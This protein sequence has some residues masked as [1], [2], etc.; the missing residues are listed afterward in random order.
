MLRPDIGSMTEPEKSS[1]ACGLAA[2]ARFCRCSANLAGVERAEKLKRWF[3]ALGA[4]LTLALGLTFPIPSLAEE[5]PTD[6]ELLGA[7]LMFGFAGLDLAPND[8]VREMLAAGQL[9]SVILFDRDVSS[10]SDRNVESPEQIKTLTSSI[11][12]ISRLPVWIAIDQEGGQVRRLKPQKGFFD[13][14]S[15]QAMGH[16]SV[17][18]TFETADQLGRELATLGINLD[19]APV[20]DVDSNPFNPVIG[21]LGRAFNSDPA[22]VSLHALA[23]GRGLAKNGVVPVLK[24]F[25]GQGCATDDTHEGAA[26]VSACWSA[27]QDLRPYAEIIASGW[28]GMIMIGHI[29]HRGLDQ[30]LPA[31][32]SRNIV[33]GLLREGLGWQGVVISDDMQMRSITDRF[34]LKESMALAIEAGVD[35]LVFGNNL[36]FDPELPG[37]VMAAGRE[38]LATGRV[39]RE[40]LLESWH[41]IQTLHQAYEQTATA[42]S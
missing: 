28:P 30:Q 5:A 41:R 29:S 26:D 24:H 18:K 20:A 36:K 12:E 8:P 35:I 21:Q 6:D 13:L 7:M 34:D 31:S 9:G 40:R 2:E 27:D 11:K 39:N 4:C 3:R 23:F 10:G 16:G 1:P 42:A 14:P 25:P 22:Q 15:A 17:A 19:L 38:L 33:T 37:S 32:L